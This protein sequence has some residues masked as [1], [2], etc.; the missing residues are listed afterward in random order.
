[1]RTIV[2]T[3]S[4]EN[5]TVKADKITVVG[6]G[7]L[8]LWQAVTLAR[9]GHSVRLIEKSAAPFSGAASRWAGAMLAPDC[10]A[11]AAPPVVRDLGQRSLELWRRAVAGIEQYGTLVV[12]PLRD[13]SELL[14]FS[15][16]T[17][18]HQSLDEM[19]IGALEPVL[20]GR[21]SAALFY[22]HE[23][24]FDCMAGLGS[25]LEA[26]RAAGVETHFGASW[27][28]ADG[29]I[30][31]DCR[32]LAAR[33]DIAGLRGVRGER[34]IVKSTEIKLARPVRLLHP[35]QPIY[36]VPQGDGR[37]VVGATVIEREDE[38]PMTVRSALELLG[39]AYALHPAF[40][41]AAILDMGAGVR[42]AFADNVPRIIIEDGGRMIRVNG[43]YRHG[44]LLGPILAEAVADF[45]ATGNRAHP[46]V[47]SPSP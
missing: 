7:V 22:A 5:P 45:V 27:T 10:E 20:A 30:V 8:G 9:A 29:G 19:A 37:F 12:A 40:A 13:Q 14:R 33:G 38:Q 44:F 28:G 41:E 15:R 17:R 21:F 16:A 25:L 26:A 39:S 36:V 32:G 23:A 42:P 2:G 47:E 1:M 43:A 18:Q 24:H 35:R 11:E 4:Q 46:L 6:A 34:L 31:I 3:A